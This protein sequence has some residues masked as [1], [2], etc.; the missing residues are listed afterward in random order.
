M[1]SSGKL[2]TAVNFNVFKASRS[3]TPNRVSPAEDPAHSRAPGAGRNQ[4]T[5]SL[6]N[7]VQSA[8]GTKNRGGFQQQIHQ[9]ALN[10]ARQFTHD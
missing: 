9:G 2:F 5:G 3:G 6:P 4:R 8:T 10:T 7:P 1:T